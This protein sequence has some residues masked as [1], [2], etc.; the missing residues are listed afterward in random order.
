MAFLSSGGGGMQTG[1]VVKDHV[2]E[3]L[4]KLLANGT[5]D[6]LRHER[7]VR[8]R[9]VVRHVRGVKSRPLQERGDDCVFL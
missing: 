7:R 8:H 5:L 6:D 1:S 2:G 3:V 9:P 4:V